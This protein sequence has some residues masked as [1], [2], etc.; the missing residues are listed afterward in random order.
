[1]RF[2]T[3]ASC[4]SLG[5]V[6]LGTLVQ[7]SPTVGDL[8]LGKPDAF[9]HPGALHTSKDIE[10]VK[11]HVKR[12]EEPWARA[13]KH[14]EGSKYAQTAWKPK[15]HKILVRGENPDYE[16]NYA[17]AYR[18]AHAAYQLAL[19]W[20]ISD[21]TS[22]ADAAVNILNAWGETVTEIAGNPDKY[23][24]AGIYGYQFANAAELIRGYS[25][26]AKEK[27]KA[28]GV[29]LNDVFAP[30]NRVFL[31][32]HNDQP[33]FY[34]AN[35]DLCNIASLM[36]IGIYN[37][38]KTMYNFAVDYFKY[39]PPS[40]VVANGALPFF[41]I[42]NYTEELTGKTLM[43]NQESGRDQ[44]HS[45]MC[46]GLLGVIGQQGYNQGVD[47]YSTYENA[48]L[49]GWEG[50]L[51]VVSSKARGDIRPGFETIYS[52]YTEIKKLNASWSKKFRDY[53]NANLTTNVEG[54]GGDYS[55]NS[56]GF[57]SLGHGKASIPPGLLVHFRFLVFRTM[58]PKVNDNMESR[59][60]KRARRSTLA[61]PDKRRGPYASR[62]CIACRRRKGKC[63]GQ[64]PCEYCENR[65]QTCVYD[66]EGAQTARR[67]ERHPVP[68]EKEPNQ[69]SQSRLES[70]T[71]TTVDGASSA[72]VF[73]PSNGS[74]PT[75]HDLSELVVSLRAQLNNVEAMVEAQRNAIGNSEPVAPR[76]T[77]PI[78][79]S[80]P[81]SELTGFSNS[82]PQATQDGRDSRATN[83]SFYSPTSPEYSMNLVQNTLRQLGY[84]TSLSQHPML[85]SVDGSDAASS[86]T[87]YWQPAP[88]YDWH[89]L[90]Q[91]R[92]WLSLQ[93]A[94]NAVFT[95]WQVL[96]DF[97]PFV[98][99]LKIQDQLETWY[100]YEPSIGDDEL[101]DED[102]I[103]LNLV[104]A[105]AALAQKDTLLAR[106]PSVL[107]SSLHH[108]ANAAITSCT[109]S[110]K[111][112]TIA[113]LLDD[114]PYMRAM[115]MLILVSDRFDEPIS[116]AA[117]G[118]SLDDDIMELL[119]FKTQ[120]WQKKSLGESSLL[121]MGAVL[122]GPS[123]PIPSSYHFLLVFRAATIRSLLFRP[124]F[125]PTSDIEKS[126]LHLRPALQLASDL[127]DYLSRLD[128]FTTIYY[129][130]RP[131]Y[132]H[133]LAS[134]CALMFL[135]A[136]YV[137]EH[138]SAMLPHLP[139]RYDDNIRD[140]F[141]TA[142]KLTEKYADIS[143][144]ANI[145]WNRIKEL[146]YAMETYGQ[147]HKHEREA[148]KEPTSSAAPRVMSTSQ[149]ATTTTRQ[150]PRST[151]EAR[152]EVFA[153]V[154]N[155]PCDAELGSFGATLG[156]DF[157]MDGDNGLQD[158]QLRGWLTN[159]HSFL[160]Q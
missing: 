98:H 22:Y 133:M 132:Q 33:D 104:F 19:R 76:D 57:D 67:P 11:A 150:L 97:H 72:D 94:R 153:N 12:K 69:G 113:L 124:Y 86:S 21:N 10:R 61:D 160:F 8:D 59:G 82:Q 105:I 109:T 38:N 149:S 79:P 43:Q 48:I 74:G 1:M 147:G 141:K 88:H 17:D 53:V 35:W 143:E 3:T 142:A 111:Q 125:F 75:T 60:T 14:L 37:D 138:R 56:G 103:I 92:S 34:Y 154:G 4:L 93:E 128:N 130:Q 63:D 18:D 36:A 121:D 70:Q 58:V 62:A 89:Q 30:M 6:S 52:H 23:L 116:L 123:V 117:K 90:L 95:Y 28:F 115:Y 152:E 140:C 127:T 81:H 29:M 112:V 26:W 126:K 85:P 137:E 101:D 83:H 49:N 148:F 40:G 16:V 108:S 73:A 151:I 159:S 110:T 80:Y 25:G 51:E 106:M 91:F 134:I 136:G 102:L 64:D 50:I 155:A 107:H 84:L 71:P 118:N 77:A 47:L 5:L 78:Q 44:A 66:G 55:P 41:S 46:F 139:E 157:S 27:Q 131:Y 156:L 114:K 100:S 2:I 158:A 96:G 144:S 54:G 120:Q 87:S 146:C 32:E 7:A 122:T 129:E 39:G 65:G 45:L 135:M 99:H 9:I 15:P 145:L 31:D 119:V 24:A 20:L 68:Q 42:A 13:F